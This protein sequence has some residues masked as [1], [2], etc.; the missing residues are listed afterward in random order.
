[1]K[2]TKEDIIE[3]T[4][5][6]IV[7]MLTIGLAISKASGLLTISW[8]WV[9]SPLWLTLGFLCAIGIVLIV[10]TLVF[11]FIFA[12][13]VDKELSDEDGVSEKKTV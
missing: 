11:Y 7:C 13:K 6:F 10:T 4:Y 1:M 3:D 9:F 8:L 2:A 12:S 5:W